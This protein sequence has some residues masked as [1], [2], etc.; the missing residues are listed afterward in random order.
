[1]PFQ[2]ERAS[3]APLRRI[4]QSDKVRNLQARFRRIDAERAAEDVS[5]SIV[6]RSTE[7]GG[8]RP[9]LIL[10]IGWRL[11]FG[12]RGYGISGGGDWLHH[13]GG[14]VDSG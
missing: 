9:D 6:P 1:M 13:S 5:R 2:N 4:L 11:C 12:R 7:I 8:Q 3:Y 10:A 14:S